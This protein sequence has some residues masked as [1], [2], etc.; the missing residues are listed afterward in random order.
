MKING[1]SDSEDLD[2]VFV[3]DRPQNSGPNKP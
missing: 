3:V 1:D 2:G